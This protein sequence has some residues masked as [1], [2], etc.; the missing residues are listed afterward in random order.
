MKA[1]T[2]KIR[3]LPND[4]KP[5][6][7]S[8]KYNMAT[9]PIP[10]DFIEFLKLLNLNNVKYLLIGGYAVG[11]HGYVR[12]TGDLD[13]WVATNKTNARKLVESIKQFGFETEHLK[14]ELFLKSNN[15]VRMG[16]PPIRIEV[17]TTISGVTFEQCYK[18]RLTQEWNGITVQVISLEKLI[19]N[20]KASGRLKDLTDAEQ[21]L[22]LL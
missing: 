19:K 11:F 15:V 3:H 17:L 6:K 21:L 5:L 12:A 16:R 1:S 18:E 9:I 14:S 8:D 7:C 13:I 10:P 20:K 4:L 22:K 2:G